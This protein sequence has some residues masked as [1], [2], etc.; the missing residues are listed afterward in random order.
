MRATPDAP[1]AHGGRAAPR[2]RARRAQGLVP[3]GDRPCEAAGRSRPRRSS[4]GSTPSAAC[5]PRWTFIALAEETGLIAAL[6]LHVL[7]E[8]C[9]QTAAWQQ[10]IDPAIGRVG[11]RSPGDRRSIPRSPRRCA[12]I[13]EHSGLRPGTL[14]LEITETVLMEEAASPVTA[15]DALREHGLTLVLDDFGTGYSSAHRR[16]RRS[17]DER[18]GGA[19][20]RRGIAVASR[21]WRS[22][23]PARR[24][25]R[26][27]SVIV[28]RWGGEV[29]E[30]AGA[31]AAPGGCAPPASRSRRDWSPG[32]LAAGAGGRLAMRLLAATSPDAEGSLTEADQI[33][34]RI[35]VDGTLGFFVFVGVP[36]GL[37]SGV[38]YALVRPL[39]P[40]GRAGGVALGALLLVLAATR[41][42]PLRADN[43]DFALVG[44]AWLAVLDVHS[45]RPVPGNARGGPGRADVAPARRRRLGSRSGSSRSGGSPSPSSCSRRCR[46]SSAA[47]TDI[48][49]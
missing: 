44:P 28:A 22:R 40:R 8:A 18:A 27:A 2:S 34:G 25:W 30:R 6:G 15:L 1:R 11:Q 37:L 20:A 4:A 43:P 16:R 29:H 24:S 17:R 19:P 38:L 5:S 46:A 9:R 21:P 31:L 26:S 3:A 35:S 33:V 41:I 47:V 42:E 32:V 49:G 13:A 36:A 12:A 7:E 23:P 39:L 48:L 14:A 45:A 10:E